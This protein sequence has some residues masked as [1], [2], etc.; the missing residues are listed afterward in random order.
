M[1]TSHIRH[2]PP[3]PPLDYPPTLMQ[4]HT[5]RK[6]AMNQLPEVLGHHS[7]PFPPP[8]LLTFWLSQPDL[9]G[10]S[11]ILLRPNA[12]LVFSVRNWQSNSLS[13]LSPHNGVHRNSAGRSPSHGRLSWLLRRTKILCNNWN[14][15]NGLRKSFA[16]DCFCT[17]TRVWTCFKDYLY[18]LLGTTPFPQS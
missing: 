14:L 15:E 9:S 7:Q 3:P 16:Q 10:M 2:H 1:V 4:R 17:P 11:S 12:S 13:L 8:N 6:P 18:I 5:H